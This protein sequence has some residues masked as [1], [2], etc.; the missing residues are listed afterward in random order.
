MT[1]NDGS[2]HEVTQI[3]HADSSCVSP[4]CR[5]CSGCGFRLFDHWVLLELQKCG[6]ITFIFP[7][8]EFLGLLGGDDKLVNIQNKPASQVAT[9]LHED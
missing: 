7:A 9:S 5:V 8:Q 1:W 4:M 3:F 6:I 2:Q